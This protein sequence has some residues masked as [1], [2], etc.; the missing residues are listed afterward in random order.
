MP[1]M[2]DSCVCPCFY[3]LIT[4]PCG[5]NHP[6]VCFENHLIWYPQW[7]ELGTTNSTDLRTTFPEIAINS[8]GI[9]DFWWK[10]HTQWISTSWVSIAWSSPPFFMGEFP[11]FHDVNAILWQ[12]K[13]IVLW[14]YCM[15]S[16]DTLAS[17]SKLV[18]QF[19]MAKFHMFGA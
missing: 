10:P 8:R 19:L 16:W 12:N 9:F 3:C 6:P 5:L 11:W 17:Q 14:L 15:D 13:S 4:S 18:K 2:L 7:P 1:A